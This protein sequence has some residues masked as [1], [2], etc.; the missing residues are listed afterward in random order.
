MEAQ[1]KT[2]SSGQSAGMLRQNKMFL[3]VMPLTIQGVWDRDKS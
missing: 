1:G 2:I 3:A